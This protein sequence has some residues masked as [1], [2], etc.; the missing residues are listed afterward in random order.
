MAGIFG[1]NSCRYNDEIIIICLL[2]IGSSILLTLICR[3]VNSGLSCCKLSNSCGSEKSTACS[4]CIAMMEGVFIFFLLMMAIIVLMCTWFMFQNG[5]PVFDA[6]SS[7]SNMYCD[8]GVYYAAV[9][10]VAVTYLSGF[11][12]A[13]YMG[14]AGFCYYMHWRELTV[15]PSRRR[16]RRHPHQQRRQDF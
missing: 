9:A 5:V 4:V 7:S 15:N 1:I 14:V 3:L 13:V 10:M 8:E 6:A 12:L 11:F 2:L 16:K